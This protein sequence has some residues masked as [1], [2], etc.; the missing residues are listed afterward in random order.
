MS[1]AVTARHNAER[2]LRYAS[3]QPTGLPRQAI[4]CV[5]H[6]REPASSSCW[7]DSGRLR[8]PAR[9]EAGV[10]TEL[11]RYFREAVRPFG[12]RVPVG[13]NAVLFLDYSELLACLA[14]DWLAGYFSL[15]WWWRELVKVHDGQRAVLRAWGRAPEHVPAAFQILSEQ[16]RAVEFARELPEEAAQEILHRMCAAHDVPYRETP[17]S[18]PATPNESTVRA[19]EVQ[20]PVAAEPAP[21]LRWVPEAA[22]PALQTVNR[23]LLAQALMLRRAPAT[24]R[25]IE[26]QDRV[27]E[28]Q[29]Q[30]FAK[31]TSKELQIAKQNK[32]QTESD[33]ETTP[34]SRAERAAEIGATQERSAVIPTSTTSKKSRFTAAEVDASDPAP[35]TV[36]ADIEM[37]AGTS[38]PLIESE[39]QSN[40]ALQPEAQLVEQAAEQ[41]TP[42]ATQA[43]DTIYGGVFFLL[44]VAIALEYYGDFT[45]PLAS[46]PELGIWDFVTQMGHR[47]SAQQ[48]QADPLWRC[49]AT[50]SGRED[51]FEMTES[52]KQWL[53]HAESQVRELLID[54]L[55]RDDA[56]EFLCRIPGH[57]VCTHTHVDAFYSM[58]THPI[59]IRIACLDRDPGWIPSAGRYVAFHF[60]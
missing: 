25:S 52:A 38:A 57:V 3:L 1:H 35:P 15:H 44:N 28:C 26:F 47:F 10:R 41:A 36:L 49:L 50:L 40:E 7:L 58:E 20:K 45:S 56:P 4:L 42:A 29:K 39:Q 16:Q 54:H 13:A 59:E 37:Q 33:R 17:H 32:R 53:D 19:Q 11:E 46:V 48:L 14:L 23:L 31:Q 24:V 55:D 34:T 22:S 27:Q 60:D 21:W 8:L 43:F 6:L 12:G 51:R 2:L 9:W 30:E 5:K 18:E